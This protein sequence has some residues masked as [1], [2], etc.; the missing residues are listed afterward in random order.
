MARHSHNDVVLDEL[1]GTR[2]ESQDSVHYPLIS[3]TPNSA[4]E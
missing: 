4:A 1:Q 2:V 3:N